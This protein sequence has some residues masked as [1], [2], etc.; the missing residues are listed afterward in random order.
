M[1]RRLESP[2]A[3]A[4]LAAALLATSVHDAAA[5]RPPAQPLKLTAELQIY[6]SRAG[7]A[8]EAKLT[9]FVP[10]RAD[11][12]DEVVYTVAFV[13]VSGRMVDQ[14]RIT[15]PI[16]PQVQYVAD[17]AYSPGGLA[18]YSID[19]GR[20][21]ALPEELFVVGADGA[22]ARATPSAYTHVRWVLRAPLED[23][24][25]GFARFRGIVR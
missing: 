23:G 3:A 10:S 16:P 4:V 19:D 11:P 21:F 24:A 13:N 6:D 18:L 1:T 22:K 7:G 8:G 2:A 9:P 20:T 25:K 14:V 12:G 15:A 5:Q 17:S